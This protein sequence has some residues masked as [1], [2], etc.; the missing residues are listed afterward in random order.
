M[1]LTKPGE[2]SITSFN[3]Y[4]RW[5]RKSVRSFSY[6]NAYFEFISGTNGGVVHPP[7]RFTDFGPVE[8]FL[9]F[10]DPD[11]EALPRAIREMNVEAYHSAIYGQVDRSLVPFALT[12]F[13]DAYCF[14]AQRQNQVVVWIHDAEQSQVT[15]HVA[16]TFE[17][18]LA[19]ERGSTGS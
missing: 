8:L 6:E 5:V 10:V 9:N 11:D 14:D 12:P 19:L 1:N 16:D 3:S 7:V 4:V 15:N 13:G 17:D 2:F 18:F